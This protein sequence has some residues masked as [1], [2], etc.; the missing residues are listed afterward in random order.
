MAQDAVVHSRPA[1]RDVDEERV[2]LVYRASH[3]LQLLLL[4]T[5]VLRHPRLLPRDGANLGLDC[6]E[7][8][9]ERR[10]ATSCLDLGLGWAECDCGCGSATLKWGSLQRGRLAGG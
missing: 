4:P 2:Q 7:V 9:V 1:C 5:F 6:L 3:V 10:V 8:L